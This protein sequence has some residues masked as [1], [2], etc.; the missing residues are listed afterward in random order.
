MISIIALVFANANLLTCSGHHFHSVGITLHV[1][2][3][4]PRSCLNSTRLWLH[5]CDVLVAGGV[6]R[7][8]SLVTKWACVIQEL[9]NEWE[10]FQLMWTL[11]QCRQ[12]KNWG[13]RN[14]AVA[15][16]GR[17]WKFYHNIAIEKT[18]LQYYYI[19][20]NIFSISM[21]LSYV[22]LFWPRDSKCEWFLLKT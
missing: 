20:H 2:N 4:H 5:V 12:W 8:K 19:Y 17:Y 3:W 1:L 18:I 14:R 22:L 16:G 11:G 9:P 13:S 10:A 6:R 15:R 21:T 7:E